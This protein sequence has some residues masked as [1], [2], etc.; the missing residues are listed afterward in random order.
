MAVI[1]ESLEGMLAPA[2]ASKVIF[3]ALEPFG[4]DLPS[5]EGLARFV[6]NELQAS[7][8]ARAG[9]EVARDITSRISS[10]LG[11]LVPGKGGNA[12]AVRLFGLMGT[13]A[14]TPLVSIIGELVGIVWW[15]FMGATFVTLETAETR[16][17]IKR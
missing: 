14:V 15:L 3:E 9:H 17:E 13:V 12:L 10:V 8:Q 2:V 4:G 5:G 11:L 16:T 7:L 1:R 6:E